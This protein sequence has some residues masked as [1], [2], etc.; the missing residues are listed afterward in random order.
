MERP[1]GSGTTRGWLSTIILFINPPQSEGN[2]SVRPL[3]F[4]P[5]S[6][7]GHSQEY[8]AP[9]DIR[10]HVA[11]VIPRRESVYVDHEMSAD[12]AT[13]VALGYKQEFKRE[14]SVWT[15]FSVSFSILGLLPSTASTLFVSLSTQLY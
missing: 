5:S 3:V 4:F 7:M 14:F 10:S 2:F 11:S 15:S 12:E 1:I 6:A 13:L 8:A 9:A